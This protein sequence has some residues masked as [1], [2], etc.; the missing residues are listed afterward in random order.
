V[1]CLE[2]ERA[3]TLQII[4][5][6]RDA[7]QHYIL[8]ISEEGLYVQAQAGVT[9]F[10]DVLGNVVGEDLADYLRERVPPVST[11]P[12]QDLRALFPPSRRGTRA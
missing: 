7:A 9:L 11:R 5:G 1:K 2:P 6:L 10:K 4:H 3:L 8:E 12:V